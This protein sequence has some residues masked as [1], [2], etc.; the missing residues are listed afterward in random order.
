MKNSHWMVT[1]TLFFIP[2]F[3]SG[4]EHVQLLT[5]KTHSRFILRV[6][7]DVPTDWHNKGDHFEL[8]LKGLNLTD[9][10]APLGEEELWASQFKDLRDSRLSSIE[11]TDTAEGVKI[12]GKWN[13]P[14]GKL[15]LAHPTMEYFN[16][17][18]KKP[19][20]FVVDFWLKPGP[21]LLEFESSKRRAKILAHLKQTQ[22]EERKRIDQKKNSEKKMIEAEDLAQYCQQ[23][24]NEKNDIFLPFN[25]VHEKI[26]FAQWYPSGRPDAGFPYFK[27]EAKD[28]ETGYVR[29]A[30]D[31][32]SNERPALAIRTLDFL[33]E[34]YPKSEFRAEMS[35][36][37]ANALIKLGYV[38]EGNDR[39]LEILTNSTPAPVTFH[40]AMYLA[41]KEMAAGQTLLALQKFLWLARNY[42][43]HR[44][45]WTFHLGQAECLYHLGQTQRAVQEYTWVAENAPTP[46][47]K[48]Q[49]AFRMGD[50]YLARFQYE[51][52]LASYAESGNNFKAE[53]TRYA[54]FYLNEGEALYQLGQYDRAEK[55]FLD[56]VAQF[57]NPPYG[58][59]ATF[60]L[61]EIWARRA[62]NREN[63]QKSRD[64]F[65][66][67]INRFPLTP[68]ATLARIRLIPCGDH[69]GFNLSAEER[70]FSGEAKKFDGDKAVVIKKYPDFR[71]LAHVRGLL[72]LSPPAQVIDAT[73]EEL[74]QV[75][76]PEI[77]S[78][79]INIAN[80][81]FKKTILD[82]LAAG[83]KYE[84][85]SL[86]AQ[87]MDQ[88]PSP[89]EALDQEH[90]LKL[91][92]VAASYG[93]GSMSEEI[94]SR[95]EKITSLNKKIELAPFTADRNLDFQVSERNFTE[96]SALWTRSRENS[97]VN[98]PKINST[99]A[100]KIRDLLQ[101]VNDESK[102]AYPK[103]IILGLLDEEE[104][105]FYSALEHA[106]HAQLLKPSLQVQG[107]IASLY[108]K[109]N[110]IPL[111]L[112]IFS[113]LEKKIALR[114]Q[115]KRPNPAEVSQEEQERLLGIP[116]VPK[117]ETLILE[118]GALLE[119]AGRWG[120]AAECYSRGVEKG[121]GGNQAVFS[122][123]KNLLKSPD[124][125]QR[126]KGEDTLE[127]LATGKTDP[128][129]GTEIAAGSNGTGRAPAT[130]AAVTTG[131]TT[132][133]AA[134]ASAR[135]TDGKEDF[136]KR[137]AK[138]TLDN[139]RI[140][141][142]LTDN[143]KEGKNE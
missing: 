85:L 59:R 91:A 140:K 93:L 96:A 54:P 100:K 17:H 131:A 125:L 45:N 56:Y 16:Y 68:G 46:G 115:L 15:K 98:A 102:F 99:D 78:K 43:E 6:D 4:N 31:L 73:V 38:Q 62:E 117:P 13:F 86:Y 51:M 132:V 5:F 65:T 52:A 133:V 22:M 37:R 25:P 138:E 7:G 19:A 81:F 130:A 40:I 128:A 110:N 87:K 39:L 137:L 71:A 33:D 120:E 95:Y 105:K 70:F 49:A 82:Y 84:A 14:T 61:G 3:A 11:L 8:M 121:Y 36:L 30:I 139:Q 18:E 53:T 58:W 88:I 27:P 135:V 90:L 21:T 113:E 66:E 142:S 75:K 1:L 129:E 69:G 60:R 97:G 20:Q 26:N 123:A 64:Y 9:L 67:T 29:L 63:R 34:E 134:G 104:K 44:L 74:S 41:A 72:D 109:T 2:A 79:M 10:G 114:A 108:E 48:A 12:K 28:K 112:N 116:L 57:P 122:Y 127:K 118:Q 77:R 119:K 24:L 23:P 32:Y 76:L 47:E 83:K 50:L 80:L 107:W 89:S 42:P 136:W 111:A 141:K 103:E 126:Q 92:Q 143:A 35:L 55:I 124:P 106:G 94:Y 101:E